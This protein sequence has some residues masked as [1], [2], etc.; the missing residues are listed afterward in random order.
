MTKRCA[1]VVILILFS[2]V[3]SQATDDMKAFPLA[4]KGMERFVLQLP[5]QDDESLF[6]VELIVGKTIRIDE[7][8][9]YFFGG[10]IEAQTIEGWGY[11][12]YTVSTLGPMGGTLMAVDPNLPLVERFITLGGEPYLVRY[13]SRLPLVVYIPEDAEVRYRIW[14]AEIEMRE[15]EKR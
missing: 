3:I 4:E 2:A 10:Q 6:R 9:R 1:F 5:P 7:G 15:M 12:R 14:G 13:N 11:T 8:N